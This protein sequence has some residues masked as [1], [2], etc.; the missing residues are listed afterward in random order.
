MAKTYNDLYLYS[1]RAFREAGI[2]AYNLEAR[3]ILSFAA[4]KP[5]DKLMQDIMLYTTDSIAQAVES[6]VARRLNASL[7]LISPAIGSFMDCLWRSPRMYSY[8][9]SIRKCL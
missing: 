8:R 2:S 9:G 6:L 1:R 5:M 7:S 3:L 4:G